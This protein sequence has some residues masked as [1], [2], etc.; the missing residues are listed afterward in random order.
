MSDIISSL[1]ELLSKFIENNPFNGYLAIIFAM[2]LENIIPP[3]PSELIMPLGGYYVSTG[4]LNFNLVVISGTIGSVIGGLPWYGLGRMFNEEKI[5]KLISDKGKWLG[6]SSNELRK[7]RN[8]FDKYG[9]KLIFW[10]RLIPGVRTLISVP[11]GIELMPLRIFLI[12]TTLGSLLWV[13]FLTS[14]GFFMGENFRKI[15]DFVGYF[16]GIIKPILF[17]LIIYFLSSR[18]LKLIRK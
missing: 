6:I 2:F 17:V 1:P 10:G 9:V 13:T 16:S 8:W 12:W 4:E 14:A 18:I 5:E 7:S 11:A 15:Q 3:I